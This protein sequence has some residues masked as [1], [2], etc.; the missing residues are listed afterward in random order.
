MLTFHVKMSLNVLPVEQFK[1]T[2]TVLTEPKL[3]AELLICHLV[4]LNYMVFSLDD[5]STIYKM[6]GLA[7]LGSITKHG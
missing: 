4:T 1:Q 6:L 5:S 3:F 7:R 2:K